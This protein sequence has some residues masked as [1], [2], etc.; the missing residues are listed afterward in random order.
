[1]VVKLMTVVWTCYAWMSASQVIDEETNWTV[2]WTSY[3]FI[4]F[5]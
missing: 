4:G 2:V 5:L 1:M 3:A